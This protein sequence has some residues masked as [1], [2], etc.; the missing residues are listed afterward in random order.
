MDCR[1]QLAETVVVFVFIITTWRFVNKRGA[2][3]GVR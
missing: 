2:V 3:C 1:L